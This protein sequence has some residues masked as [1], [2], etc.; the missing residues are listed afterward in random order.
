MRIAYIMQNGANILQPPFDGPAE[1]VRNVVFELKRL[2]NDVKILFC[3]K[4]KYYFSEDLVNFK[5]I[6][7]KT[8]EN[9]LL[10][11]VEKAIRR[12]QSTLH[13]PYLAW[14]ESL[15]FSRVCQKYCSDVDI[16]LE[17]ISWMG[18]G[19]IYLKR[20]LK[21]PLVIEFNGDPL[22]DL[23]AKN[24]SPR[25]IQ[26]L[27]SRRLYQ[28]VL[29]N[30]DRIIASG[31][32]WHQNLIMHWKVSPSK[33]ETIENGTLLVDLLKKKDLKSFSNSV[34][35]DTRLKIIYLGGFYPWHGT[36][37]LLKAF[38]TCIMEYPDLELILIGAGDGFE[39][40]KK[41]AAEQG[42]KEKI[43][44]TGQLSAVEYAP[45]LAT[46]DI[47]VSPYCGWVEYSGLKIFDYKAA[48]L[49]IIASGE[50]NQPTTISHG[51]SGIIIPPCDLTALIDNLKMLIKNQEL[52][53]EL[54]RNARL[55]AEK[56]HSWQTTGLH[57]ANLLQNVLD[58]VV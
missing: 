18:Y 19:S 1:H 31:E 16:F 17:R 2:G 7:P 14:F 23:K 48:G 4:G 10:R 57:V 47:A 15:R 36:D 28:F 45:L 50:N 35:S 3:I 43:K 30:A 32:G 46:S 26:L 41:N 49:A 27:L 34:I 58:K 6:D 9:R 37:Y 21:K 51:K 12:V 52:R 38:K 22:H 55:D 29:K 13:L 54:G 8:S 53:T 5:L 33:I 42:M 20:K 44:F 56:F 39:E 11:L 24:E 25:G 40:T